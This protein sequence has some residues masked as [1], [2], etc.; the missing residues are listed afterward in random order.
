MKD[1]PSAPESYPPT[2]DPTQGGGDGIIRTGWEYDKDSLL[3]STIDDDGNV[4]LYLYDDLNRQVL[5]SEGLVVDS[6][7]TE[8]NILGSRVIPTPT[9]A[10]IDDPSTIPDSLIDAQLTEAQSLIASVASLFPPLASQINDSPPTTQVWGYSPNSD[11]LIYQDE[12]GSETFAKYDAIDRPI[13]VRIFRA[14]GDDRP[15]EQ[16]RGR[17]DLRPDA[18]LDPDGAGQHDR[19]AGYDHPELPI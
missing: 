18:D 9:A 16:L 2:P 8:S 14:A 7:Y 5:E 15:A 1:T 13:A 17:P 6:S 10:T 3:S 11:V 19:R 12:N 4:T